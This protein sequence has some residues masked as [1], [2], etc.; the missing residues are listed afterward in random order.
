MAREEIIEKLDKFLTK[1]PIFEEECHVV[2]LLVEIRKLLDRDNN[3]D[4]LLARF[5]CNWTVHTTK[6][7]HE[8]IKEIIDKIDE[9]YPASSHHP[10]KDD[11]IFDFLNMNALKKELRELFDRYSLPTSVF[12]D[13]GW[14]AFVDIL[15]EVLSDQ[16]ILKPKTGIES[17]GLISFGKGRSTIDIKFNDGRTDSMAGGER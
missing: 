6:E 13:N 16:P 9:C 5:Y 14:S 12:E 8:V 1:Y 4:F 10:I 15:T 7:N 2:Y 17:I 3:P 11:G